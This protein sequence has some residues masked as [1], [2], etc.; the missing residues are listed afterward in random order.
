MEL[1]GLFLDTTKPLIVIHNMGKC[2]L[3]AMWADTYANDGRRSP[4]I[5]FLSTQ[6]QR[7]GCPP[8]S[9][10]ECRSDK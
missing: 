8:A 10:G 9:V 7:C 3:C 5:H 4:L 1:A 2:P 6:V